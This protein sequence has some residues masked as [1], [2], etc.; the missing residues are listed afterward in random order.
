MPSDKLKVLLL[1]G[2]D[3]DE[4]GAATVCLADAED[5]VSFSKNN[6]NSKEADSVS[7]EVSLES[8]SKEETTPNVQPSCENYKFMFIVLAF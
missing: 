4:H 8:R 7:S 1:P 5:T 3:N 2:N 6:N